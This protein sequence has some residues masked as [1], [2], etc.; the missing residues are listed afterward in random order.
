M[1]E[2]KLLLNNTEACYGIFKAHD[3]RFDGRVFVGASSTGIYCRP[4]CHARMP[5]IDNCTFFPSASAAEAAGYRPCLRCRPELA[6]GSA[7]VDASSQKARRAAHIIDNELLTDSCITNLAESLEITDRH[8]RRIF[9]AEYGVTPVRYLQTRRLLLAKSLLTETQLP[10][11]TVAMNC[12]FGSIRRFNDVFKKH[13]RLAPTR[14]RKEK[15]DTSNDHLGISLMVGYRP[16]FLWDQ[17][18]KCISNYQIEGVDYIKKG[19][20]YRTIVIQENGKNYMGWISVANRPKKSSIVVT[21]SESLLPVLP[22]VLTRVRQVFD[23][24][25]SPMKI[26]DRLS[27]L[28]QFAPDICLPGTRIVGCFD[29]VEAGVRVLLSEDLN[30]QK[31]SQ[32]LRSFCQKYGEE[33]NTPYPELKYYF[34]TAKD[35]ASSN[36]KWTECL[37]KD[38]SEENLDLIVSYVKALAEDES[39]LNINSDPLQEIKKMQDLLGFEV[40]TAEHIA[41]LLFA[42]PDA[43]YCTNKQLDNLFGDRAEEERQEI[44]Q[45]WKPWL[46]YVSTMVRNIQSV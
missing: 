21:L 33:A 9:K 23:L 29:P 24:D 12:G 35:L 45:T 38:I 22:K 42:W 10:I 17:I 20:Y 6:P 19:V 13:Y 18:L 41:M 34:P 14:L 26:Y 16:P 25:C 44:L 46:S 39:L 40:A 8:L 1:I 37:G 36:S 11:T 30:S 2:I 31:T 28:N 3:S 43:F 32:I 5:K 7:P 4:V 15:T 27:S